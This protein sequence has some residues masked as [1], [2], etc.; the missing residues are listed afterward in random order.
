MKTFNAG[1]APLRQPPPEILRMIFLDVFP[2]AFLLDA[3]LTPGP[4]S[5][6][7]LST[8]M[9]LSMMSVCKIWY[10]IAVEMLYE[11][12]S[13]RRIGQISAFLR[14]LRNNPYLGSLVKAVS[15]HC[16]VPHGY[17]T[18]LHQNLERIISDCS[19]ISRIAFSVPY[20][21]QLYQTLPSL[22]YKNITQIE[23]GP[24]IGFD[25]LSSALSELGAVLVSLSMHIPL[26][27]LLTT[28]PLRLQSLKKLRFRIGH[29]SQNTVSNLASQ[30]IMPSL[31]SLT[32]DIDGEPFHRMSCWKQFC[33][34]HGRN[35]KCLVIVP[36][37]WRHAKKSRLHELQD[38]LDLCPSLEHIVIP[39]FYE[40]E[41]D[42]SHPNVKWIDIWRS[43]HSSQVPEFPIH[44]GFPAFRG[45]RAVD[46]AFVNT[47]DITTLFPPDEVIDTARS[48]EYRFPGIQVRH[49]PRHLYMMYT[50]DDD[51]EDTDY[52][53]AEDESE[54]DEEIDDDSLSD[55]SSIENGT[56]DTLI[57]ERM[58]DDAWWQADNETALGIYLQSES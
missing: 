38:L 33:T 14:T 16:F 55:G 54:D 2:P 5:P 37:P 36:I 7:C 13:F 56:S 8:Q 50:L 29:K 42:V 21:V 15:V 31:Q 49:D 20:T 39:P 46:C 12:I 43:T 1:R 34:S 28:R 18:L 4:E 17:S 51:D 26:V 32:F 23:F 48:F 58:P 30:W 40:I 6:W 45:F 27:P 44:R 53:S 19:R 9:K 35:L 3:S 10:R 22:T 24:T 57:D 41:L 47:P 11:D 25:S 52:E